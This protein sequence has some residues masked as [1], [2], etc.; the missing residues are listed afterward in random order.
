MTE[1]SPTAQRR[2]VGTLLRAHRE[3]VG[4]MLAEAAEKAGVSAAKLSR[5]ERGLRGLHVADVRTL[6]GLYRLSEEETRELLSAT[7]ASREPGWWEAFSG[8]ADSAPMFFGLELAASRVEEYDSLC[9]PGVLQTAAYALALLRRIRPP[10]S[11]SDDSVAELV[12]ARMRRSSLLLPRQEKEFHFI[13]DEAAVRRVVESP[14]VMERQVASVVDA[15]S[16]DNVRVQVLP[17]AAGAHPGLSGAFAIQVFDQAA[18]RDAVFVEGLAGGLLI[19]HEAQVAR[20]REAFRYLEAKALSG[21][22]SLRFLRA[23]RRDWTQHS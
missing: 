15:M 7:R 20:Y 3:R 18:Q 13:I 2:E 1:T 22:D 23:V 6:C 5:L 14:Q 17:F 9:V 12:E 8:L 10:G 16:A 19:E 11:M 4:L 21:R